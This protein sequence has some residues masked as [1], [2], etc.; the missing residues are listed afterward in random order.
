MVRPFAQVQ[1][2]FGVSAGCVRRLFFFRPVCWAAR[3]KTFTFFP[4]TLAVVVAAVASS[5][6]PLAGARSMVGHAQDA[7][8]FFFGTKDRYLI[9]FALRHH[10]PGHRQ[11]TFL[12]ARSSR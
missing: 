4:P 8:C 6:L 3:L 9:I 5:D 1:S 2:G 7:A 10:Q 11:M 12:L